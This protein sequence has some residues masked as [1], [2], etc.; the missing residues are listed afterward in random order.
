MTCKDR[1]I[2]SYVIR[3]G[4]R[5][6]LNYIILYLSIIN[7]GT[8]L[9]YGMDK[10]KARQNKWRIPEKTLLGAAFLGGSVGAWL[11]MQVFHHKTKHWKFRILVPLFLLMHATLLIIMGRFL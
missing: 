9:L 2:H 5:K 1:W 8:F 6:M 7:I 3:N 10:E 4:E 11:G